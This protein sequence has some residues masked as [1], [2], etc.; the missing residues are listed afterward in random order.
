MRDNSA[1]HS[2]GEQWVRSA[3]ELH[4]YICQI[5]R[6]TPAVR[7]SEGLYLFLPYEVRGA[8]EGSVRPSWMRSGASWKSHGWANLPMGT[9][10]EVLI[11]H[12]RGYAH[13]TNLPPLLH[14]IHFCPSLFLPFR[15]FHF[16]SHILTRRFLIFRN[17]K[18]S[19]AFWLISWLCGNL[20]S[21]MARRKIVTT[22]PNNKDTRI[23]IIK[24]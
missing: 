17:G 18:P 12:P 5:V 16:F 19:R 3:K 22:T 9:R 8:S 11:R 4:V 23:F 24:T 13:L 7:R 10:R 6:G 21:R 14:I 15:R 1:I 2:L 20:S